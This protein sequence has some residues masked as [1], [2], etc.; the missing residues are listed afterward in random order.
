M[1]QLVELGCV[2]SGQLFLVIGLWKSWATL[3]LVIICC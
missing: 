2:R 3:V 1:S